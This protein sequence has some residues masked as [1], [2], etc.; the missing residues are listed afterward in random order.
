MISKTKTSLRFL[1]ILVLTIISFEMQAQNITLDVTNKTLKEVLAQIESESEYIFIYNDK[2]V[3]TN[4]RIS[5]NVSDASIKYVMSE[6]LKGTD[7][8]YMLDG[9]QITIFRKE[10][11]VE[12]PDIVPAKPA[13][14]VV[15]GRIVDNNGQSVI[16]AS[17]IE[18]GTGHGVMAD[19]DGN[20]SIEIEERSA[21][22]VYSAMGYTTQE[23]KVSDRGNINVILRED[24]TQLEEVV[25]IG[26][27]TQ[28]KASITGALSIVDTD[29]LTHAPVSSV[30]NVLAGSVPGVST[31]QTSGQ[32]GKDAAS[33][34]IRGTGS[35]SSSLSAPLVLVDGV[36]RDFSQ[37]DPNE[38]ENMSILKDAASTAVFGIRGANGVILI[39][40]KR[41]KE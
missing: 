10:K 32:P 16:G 39:T 29:A 12:K 2:G 22:L 31:V 5:V 35:L 23:Q 27:G 7:L 36:E 30:T 40:T 8:S 11:S 38:V 18:K 4:R 17:V 19:L 24:F 33:I 14:L 34:Y 25:V 6:I 15:K 41:G 9:R 28:T 13:K 1:L 21:V 37:I 3:D 26:Y 20:Y